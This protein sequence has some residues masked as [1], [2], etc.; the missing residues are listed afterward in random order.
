MALALGCVLVLQGQLTAEQLTNFI[1]YVEFVTYAS[2][3]A[4]DEIVEVMLILLGEL[5]AVAHAS[6]AQHSV[7]HAAQALHRPTA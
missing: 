7:A 2:L 3:S 4:C 1:F 6:S 5:S